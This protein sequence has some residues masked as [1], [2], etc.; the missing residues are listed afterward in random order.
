ME[1]LSQYYGI[2]LLAMVMTIFGIYLLGNKQKSG[3]IVHCIGIFYFIIG[4]HVYVCIFFIWLIGYK[5]NIINDVGG[6]FG[7]IISYILTSVGKMWS[8]EI[9]LKFFLEGE[10]IHSCE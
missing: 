9:N 4:C 7:D 2:D 5:D 3:F 8:V 1:F 10:G 6:I